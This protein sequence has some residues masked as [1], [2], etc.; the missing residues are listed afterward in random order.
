M[1]LDYLKK[2]L[3]KEWLAQKEKEKDNGFTKSPEQKSENGEGKL[4]NDYS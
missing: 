2:N 4:N 3:S 1:Y